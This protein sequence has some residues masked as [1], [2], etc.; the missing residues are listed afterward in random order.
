MSCKFCYEPVLVNATCREHWLMGLPTIL[1]K[2]LGKDLLNEIVTFAGADQ[3]AFFVGF[4]AV[5]NRLRFPL[6]EKWMKDKIFVKAS[7]SKT[8]DRT[9]LGFGKYS[10]CALEDIP[11]GYLQW[12][13]GNT[14]K[15]ELKKILS[16]HLAHREEKPRS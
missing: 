11:S 8:F 14:N 4:S 2:R 10:K 12:L 1:Y 5:P 13:L 9:L 6:Y 3:E 16:T 15:P 7:K